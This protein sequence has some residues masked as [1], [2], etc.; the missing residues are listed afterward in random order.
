MKDGASE[1]AGSAM[2]SSRDIAAGAAAPRKTPPSSA[3]DAG[4]EAA[5]DVRDKASDY[6]NRAGKTLLD[7][8]QENPLLVAGVGLLIGRADRECASQE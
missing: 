4:L 7:T 3:A 2:D 5:R 6:S 8:I 1:L